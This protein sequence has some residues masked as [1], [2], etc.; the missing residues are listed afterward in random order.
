MSQNR[1]LVDSLECYMEDLVESFEDFVK[2]SLI[3]MF[4]GV[5]TMVMMLIYMLKVIT[6]RTGTPNASA[7]N[8]DSCSMV[9]LR[10]RIAKHCY[11]VLMDDDGGIFILSHI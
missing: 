11:I 5:G 10:P 8:D 4:V 3:L 7:G 2:K 6:D 9:E 1:A